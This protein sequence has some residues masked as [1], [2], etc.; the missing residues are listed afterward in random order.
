MASAAVLATCVSAQG[1]WVFMGESLHLSGLWRI[2]FFAF[3]ENT[4]ITSALRARAAQRTGASTGLDGIA[5][6]LLTGLSALLS[7]T[8]AT[9]ILRLT[10]PLVA[11]WA[12][13]ATWRWSAT[14]TATDTVSSRPSPRSVAHLAGPAGTEPRSHLGPAAHS[15]RCGAR[16]R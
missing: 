8:D 11:A 13:T 7:A 6:W 5:M 1:M 2:V 4:V 9:V 15:G 16:G 12:G 10:A 3:L 14:T